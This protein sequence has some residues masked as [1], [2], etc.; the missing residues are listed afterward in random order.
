MGAVFTTACSAVS[1]VEGEEMAACAATSAKEA[2][3][4]SR[5]GACAA[6]W[7]RREG[8]AGRMCLPCLALH[9]KGRV[10]GQAA[11]SQWRFPP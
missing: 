10:Q 7:R 11:S 6:L 2:D 5:A 1:A 4:C 8:P 3:A 9:V